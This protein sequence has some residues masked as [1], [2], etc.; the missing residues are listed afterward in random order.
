MLTEEQKKDAARLARYI[1]REQ[2]VSVMNDTKWGRLF[3]ALAPIQGW[4]DF[5]RKD[6]RG[7]DD[8]SRWGGDVWCGDFYYSFGGE[9]NIEWIDIRA[10]LE[11][12]R[13]ALVKPTIEDKTPP[14]IEA[15]RS[16]GV[17][18]SRLEDC[19]R[20]WGYIRPGISPEWE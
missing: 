2:L 18:F 20:I 3:S 13:G 11:I 9:N 14:L 15:V 19:I 12:R 10:R 5:R 17:P 16:A 8:A 4:L 7:C 6:V 1:E